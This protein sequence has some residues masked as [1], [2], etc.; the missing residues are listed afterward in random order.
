MALM[1]GSASGLLN[2]VLSE[3][4]MGCSTD[5]DCSLLG[6]CA[7][8]RC[9]CD[10]GWSGADCGQLSLLPVRHGTGYNLTGSTPATS[11]W[12][13]NIFPSSSDT[14]SQTWHMLASEFENHC[15]ISRWSPNSAIVHAVSSV[16]PEGPYVRKAVAVPA[17]AHNPKV[18]QAPDGTWL[19]YTIGVPL[20]KSQLYNC[21][22]KQQQ[23]P[24]PNRDSRPGT[25]RP[26]R[27]PSNRESNITLYTASSLDGPWVSHGVVLGADSYASWDE[28]TSNP[29]PWVLPNGTLLLVYRGCVV[30]ACPPGSICGCDREHL[31]IASAPHWRGAYTRL[32]TD[33]PILPS[34]AAEDPSLWIDERGHFH[35]LMHYIPE[36]QLVARHAFARAYTG[37]WQMHTD[38][39]PYTT[40]VAF[41]DG[42]ELTYHKRERPQLVWSG[43]APSHLITGVVQ[44]GDQ[45]G[46][47]G[48]SF[49]LIQRINASRHR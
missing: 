15:D 32:S 11:S 2:H 35:L 8:G 17:F 27:N 7:S 29:A 30:I 16:G 24:L 31:G 14:M 20:P 45:H 1:V 47:A 42:T 49:T 19:M 44:P 18:V 12:G 25:R 9:L 4:A 38:S 41:T 21:S 10:P 6:V 37:P 13:A 43:G 33:G 40:T 26:G 39:I 34:A 48:G 3:R 46:Y 5:E 23:Q 36:A 22:G 28:D